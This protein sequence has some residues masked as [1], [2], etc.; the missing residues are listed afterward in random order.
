MVMIVPTETQQAASQNATVPSTA[1]IAGATG[2]FVPTGRNMQIGL[3]NAQIAQN[4]ISNIPLTS[5]SSASQMSAAGSTP[6]AIGNQVAD[7][8]LGYR[9]NQAS[10]LQPAVANT[11]EQAGTASALSMNQA[12]N[13]SNLATNLQNNY[14]STWQPVANQFASDAAS[15]GGP[16]D[17]AAAAAKAGATADSAAADAQAATQRK[18]ASMGV[19]PNSGK[20]QDALASG[21]VTSAASKAAQ[22]TAAATDAKDKGIALRAQAAQLGNTALNTANSTAS[23]A[24]T[25]G[26]NAANAANT[27]ITD[28]LNVASMVGQG[29]NAQ[30]SAQ[31]TSMGADNA[32]A[33]LAAQ[34][35]QY[36]NARDSQ[37]TSNW[38][39]AAS[40]LGT[41]ISSLW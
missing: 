6:A 39:N 7:N 17:Q 8:N 19:N 15:Y 2:T 21:D 16:A 27:G 18:L 30:Q 40:S 36:Q 22:M 24:S 33:Q 25:L 28:G 35:E 9:L 10:L 41:L 11:L 1:Q 32:A 34:K 26:T 5:T 20:Y 29:F 12:N 38:V 23:L 37:D 14:T 31:A 4:G 13:A 3:T